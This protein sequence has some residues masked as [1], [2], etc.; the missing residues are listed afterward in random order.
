[1]FAVRV[2]AVATPLLFVVAVA[3][4]D[5]LNAA[6]A[7][8]LGAVNVTV[9]P[10]TRF[11]PLSFTVA[12]SAVANAA[13]IIALWGVPALVETLAGGPGLL[14]KLK[15]ADVPTPETLAVTV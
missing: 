12:C 3:V 8:L 6:L 7:P 5:P 15:L 11:P 9:T 1:V 4:A 13:V 14:V 10:L 2:G